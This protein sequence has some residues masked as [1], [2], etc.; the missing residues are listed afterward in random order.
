MP[1]SILG[2]IVHCEDCDADQHHSWKELLAA[3]IRLSAGS[4]EPAAVHISQGNPESFAKWDWCRGYAAAKLSDHH[5][6][7]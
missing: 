1:D 5:R 4:N 2:L 6:F 7:L 3:L